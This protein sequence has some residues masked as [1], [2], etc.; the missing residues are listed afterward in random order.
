MYIIT[1]FLEKSQ[2]LA[3]GIEIHPLREFGRLPVIPLVA[4][5]W[6]IDKWLAAFGTNLIGRGNVF[7][8]FT[9]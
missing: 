7:A 1:Y 9:F 4:H 5:R 3:V 2:P 8:K 6:V